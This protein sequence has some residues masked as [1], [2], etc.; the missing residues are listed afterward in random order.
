MSLNLFLAILTPLY[1][2]ELCFCFAYYQ[3]SAHLECAESTWD[4]L[5]YELEASLC[6]QY[7]ATYYGFNIEEMSLFEIT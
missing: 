7:V 3:R 5:K 4:N 2:E 6:I 1:K